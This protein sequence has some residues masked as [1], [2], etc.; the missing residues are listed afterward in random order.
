MSRQ[1]SSQQ[2]SSER[3]KSKE[4]PPAIAQSDITD[5]EHSLEQGVSFLHWKCK[6]ES[7]KNWK[8]AAGGFCEFC[9]WKRDHL[10]LSDIQA[11][12]TWIPSNIPLSTPKTDTNHE[13]PGKLKIN[14]SRSM[15]FSPNRLF[16]LN[17]ENFSQIQNGFYGNYREIFEVRRSVVFNNE[18]RTLFQ[19]Q[20]SQRAY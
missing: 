16:F 13:N 12:F 19:G 17:C 11:S 7:W 18:W 6:R 1:V 8:N 14:A 4:V 15:G 10:I 9:T 2:P 20:I 5:F 3:H